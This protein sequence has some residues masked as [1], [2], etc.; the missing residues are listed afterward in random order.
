MADRPCVSRGVQ[1]QLLYEVGRFRDAEALLLAEIRHDSRS[2]DAY[3]LLTEI[4]RA[5]GNLPREIVVLEAWLSLDAGNPALWSRLGEVNSVLARWENAVIAYRHATNKAPDVP[6]YWYGL[7]MAQFGAQ[8]LHEA[9]ITRDRLIRDFPDS[10]GAHLVDGHL[11]KAIGETGAAITAYRRALALE[12]ML[13]TAIYNL[14]DTST[15]SIEDPL[16]IHIDKL[17]GRDDLEDADR[18][19]LEFAAARILDRAGDTASAFECYCRANAAALRTTTRRGIVYDPEASRKRALGR[20]R[21]Y[22]GQRGSRPIRGSA[23]RPVPVFVI[24]LP[25]SGTTLVEQILGSHSQ[26]ATGGELS[27]AHEC[28]AAFMRRRAAMGIDGP[29]DPG[30]A[31]EASLLAELREKYLQGLS[32]LDLNARYVTD[33]LPANFEIAGF[34]H[35]MFPESPII[36]VQRDLM[37]TCWSLFSAN[38]GAHLPYYHSFEHLAH[39]AGL[40]LRLMQHWRRTIRP[41]LVE[42]RY[43]DLVAC[44]KAEVSRLLAAM[45]LPWEDACLAFHE[46]A[47]PVLTASHHQVRQPLYTTAVDSW[48]RYEIWLESLARSLD[49]SVGGMSRGGNPMSQ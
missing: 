33:K 16:A 39:Y 48:R 49:A 37:A 12:P 21:V 46:H 5:L 20:M 9:G 26:V 38:L 10:A 40:Y 2:I 28:E 4:Q 18:A 43:E 41:A 14:V 45:T 1:A 35:L 15:P 31:A 34:I 23:D 29:V 30:N 36:H 22:P 11:R 44:P 7:A 6:G 47:R 32:G 8:R 13:C 42:I 27:L 24:G 17:R 25:R 19:N 3:R